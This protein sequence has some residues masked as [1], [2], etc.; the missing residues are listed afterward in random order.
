MEEAKKALEDIKE[1]AKVLVEYCSNNRCSGCPLKGAV[2]DT[3]E[4]SEIVEAIEEWQSD[5]GR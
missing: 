2:C 5:E 3:L 4:F 1:S